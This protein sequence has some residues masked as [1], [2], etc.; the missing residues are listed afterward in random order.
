MGRLILLASVLFNARLIQTLS[1]Y[2]SVK[3]Q[4]TGNPPHLEATTKFGP[5]SSS[6]PGFDSVHSSEYIISDTL[7]TFVCSF[8]FFPQYSI[9]TVKSFFLRVSS[10]IRFYLLNLYASRTVCDLQHPFVIILFLFLPHHHILFVAFQHTHPLDNP[11]FPYIPASILHIPAPYRVF[12]S[13]LISKKIYILLYITITHSLFSS[14][15]YGRSR[16]K[17]IST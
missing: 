8:S 10:R 4:I 1:R 6:S 14:C 15:F 16:H 3:T 2:D 5:H 17:Y 12:P 13:F 9:E 11:H 7:R